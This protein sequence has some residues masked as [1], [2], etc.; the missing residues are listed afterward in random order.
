MA[1]AGLP[2]GGGDGDAI[3]LGILNVMR[4]NGIREGH[5]PVRNCPHM[6]VIV[7]C[8]ALLGLESYIIL[9][10]MRKNNIREGHC[11]VRTSGAL[12]KWLKMSV[13]VLREALLAL[14]PTLSAYEVSLSCTEMAFE[15]GHCPVRTSPGDAGSPC[16]Q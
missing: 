1:L 16:P 3:R 5:R 9:N 4:E 15:K 7:S 10:D 6:S 11:P 8:E 13:R 14:G 2:R 12:H